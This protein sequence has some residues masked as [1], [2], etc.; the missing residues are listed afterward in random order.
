M[1]QRTFISKEQKGGKGIQDM[2]LRGIQELIDTT[3][4]E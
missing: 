1:L 2:N 4:E 3:P